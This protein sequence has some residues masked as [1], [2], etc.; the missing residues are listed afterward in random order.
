[1]RLVEIVRTKKTSD[2][3]LA[4][5][6]AVARKIR[7]LPV[8]ARVCEG[9][10]GNRIYSAESA[11]VREIL[12]EEGAYP[13]EVDAALERFGFTMGPFAVG[14]LSGLDIAWRTAPCSAL[15]GL[16]HASAMWR[17][18]IVYAK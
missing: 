5:A 18:P 14:D 15:S 6:F 7:K 4:T 1:M 3:A 12:L 13:E 10:I 2:D 11:R 17:F 16:I 8:V 9:F